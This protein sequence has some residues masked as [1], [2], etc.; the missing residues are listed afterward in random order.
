MLYYNM[1]SQLGD[2]L[3]IDLSMAD[4][5]TVLQLADIAVWGIP[6]TNHECSLWTA[7]ANLNLRQL[8]GILLTY[9]DLSSQPFHSYA[10]DLSK[11]GKQSE[12][13][14]KPPGIID[15]WITWSYETNN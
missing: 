8:E 9:Y 12:L 7:T 2:K 3:S 11:Y 6:L 4:K 15:D 14:P 13:T 5:E 1:S 10:Y